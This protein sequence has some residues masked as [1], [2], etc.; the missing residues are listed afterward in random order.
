MENNLKSRL[1]EFISAK[2]MSIRRFELECGLPNAY[3]SNLRNNITARRLDTITAKFPD[4]NLQWLMT[5]EGVMSRTEPE[6]HAG[7]ADAGLEKRLGDMNL[8]MIRMLREFVEREKRIAESYRESIDRL[9]EQNARL[10]GIIERLLADRQ[11][12]N[13]ETH[14]KT[15][16]G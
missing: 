11:E 5:G 4:L 12:G 16:I 8:Q 1:V 13:S 2:G 6:D 15:V 10:T 9:Q 7:E 3:V 14:T